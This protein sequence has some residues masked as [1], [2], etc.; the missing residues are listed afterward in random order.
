[1]EPEEITVPGVIRLTCIECEDK[2]L[3]SFSGPQGGTAGEY[4][5]PECGHT[6]VLDADPE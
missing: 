2:R 4:E 1:M 6:V 5:C 3:F